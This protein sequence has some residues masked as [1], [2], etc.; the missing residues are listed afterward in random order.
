MVCLNGFTNEFDVP[1]Y[2]SKLKYRLNSDIFRK[3]PNGEYD[4]NY[5]N[6]YINCHY[7]QAFL[8]N[9]GNFV[10]EAIVT[11]LK[12]DMHKKELD[13]GIDNGNHD[14]FFDVI[15]IVTTDNVT[16]ACI[17]RRYEEYEID[18]SSLHTRLPIV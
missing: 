5:I 3:L 2:H 14:R 18:F 17:Y 1:R 8:L 15:N 16:V 9:H 10:Q 7:Y 4:W 13:V 6:H 11:T 12:V